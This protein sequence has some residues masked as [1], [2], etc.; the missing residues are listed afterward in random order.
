[1]RSDFPEWKVCVL[2]RDI[3]LGGGLALWGVDLPA[4]VGCLSLKFS[5]I[6]KNRR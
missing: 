1:V 5:V 2:R 6:V 4:G 3:T